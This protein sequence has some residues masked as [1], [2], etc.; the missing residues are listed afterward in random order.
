MDYILLKN[1]NI[2]Y[3]VSID[4]FKDTNDRFRGEG[5]Y[6]AIISAL[7]VLRANREIWGSFTTLRKENFDEVCSKKSLDSLVREGV[8][9]AAFIK[10]K[11][12]SNSSLNKNDFDFAKSKI[13]HLSRDLP[14]FVIM[15]GNGKGYAETEDFCYRTLFVNP[16][17]DVRLSKV[18]LEERWGNILSEDLREILMRVQA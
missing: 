16:V 10:L 2:S 15:G 8:K 6:K 7:A 3:F 4:G 9:I 13:N 18:H 12:N 17:G 1:Y 5:S 11:T 14:L